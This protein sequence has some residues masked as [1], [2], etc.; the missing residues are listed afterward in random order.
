VGMRRAAGTV[1]LYRIRNRSVLTNVASTDNG[2]VKAQRECDDNGSLRFEE[3]PKVAADKNVIGPNDCAEVTC[4][5]G[6]RIALS[7]LLKSVTSVRN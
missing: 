3:F 6:I 2:C 4:N 7:N 1:L 5:P